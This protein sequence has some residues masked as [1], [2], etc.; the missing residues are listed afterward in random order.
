M[1][2]KLFASLTISLFRFAIASRN[3]LMR[4]AKVIGMLLIIELI[5]VVLFASLTVFIEGFMFSE[6]ACKFTCISD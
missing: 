5:Y 4:G 2:I 1:L 6:F 3:K